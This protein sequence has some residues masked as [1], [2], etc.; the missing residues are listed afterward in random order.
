MF[1]CI[2]ELRRLAQA[3]TRLTCV[4]D[5]SGADLGQDT[6]YNAWRLSPFPPAVLPT[7]R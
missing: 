4:S 5:V 7:G 2:V 6:D 3:V 1:G